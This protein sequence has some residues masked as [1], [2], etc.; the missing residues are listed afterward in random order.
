[1]DPGSPAAR[2]GLSAG[3]AITRACGQPL[4]DIIDWQWL[5]DDNTVELD[6]LR[7]E[8]HA[9]RTVTLTR[10]LGE[11]WGISFAETVFDGVRTCR[12]RLRVLLH[13][14]APKGTAPC[15]LPA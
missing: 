15:A 3:D 4:R 5:S 1:V 8:D 2:A 10:A 11:Q 12:N 9:E 7:S 13:G 6:V 14:S